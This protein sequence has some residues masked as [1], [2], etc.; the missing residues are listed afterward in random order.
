VVKTKTRAP[1][2]LESKESFSSR[3]RQGAWL[4]AFAAAFCALGDF[5]AM[6]L[7]LP[8]WRDRGLLLVK[9]L[10]TLVPLGFLAGP[11]VAGLL[12]ASTRLA[13]RRTGEV[14]AARFPWFL[15]ALGALPLHLLA[16][17]LC[18]G[19]MMSRLPQRGG[20]EVALT[21]LLPALL[22]G[23]L[24]AAFKG[25]RWAA[26]NQRRN[27]SLAA[28]LAA[29][30]F[31]LGKL[32]QTLYPNLY[33]YLHGGL[34]VVTWLC[35]GVVGALL[36]SDPRVGLVARRAAT[37]KHT[38]L[39][40]LVLTAVLAA[41]A[42]GLDDHLNVRVAM[43]DPRSPI[44]RSLLAAIDPV[45]S[46]MAKPPVRTHDR[47]LERAIVDTRGLPTR[48]G[49]HVVLVTIDAL[50]AD[51][52][53]LYG[54]A[55]PTSPALDALAKDSVVFA[56]AYAQAPHSS[57]SLT[58]LHT[59]EYMHE[60]VDLERPLP[61]ATLAQTFRDQGYH[62]AA[63]FTDG[64]FHTEGHRLQPYR[65][66]AFDFALF[67][68]T[69]REAEGQTDRVLAEADRVVQRG[70]TPS[71]FWV[72]YFD[73]HEPY[74]DTHFG[75][76]DVDR[77]DSEILH[78]DR[79]LARLLR[80]LDERFERDVVVAISADHG[81]EFR[82]HGGV[83][84]GSTLFDEQ[85]R[86][87]LIL[88]STGLPPSVVRAPVE[89]I[90]IAPTL[91][92]T[93]GIAPPASMRGKDL[94]AYDGETAAGSLAAFSAVISKRMAVR[95][96]YKLVADLRFGLYELYD[97][98]VD[99][100][101]RRNLAGS[102]PRVLE[103]MRGL[104]YAWLDSL[105]ADPGAQ[106]K[107]EPLYE[108]ALRWGRLG[109]R[110][111]V[112]PMVQLLRDTSA[113]TADRIE[114][115]Q[116]LA[117]LADE[118]SAEALFAALD[119]QP[120]EVAAEAAIALGRMYDERPREH[121][122]RLMD[123]EDPYVRARAAISLGRLRDA[124]AVDA[125]IDALW[126]A[127][128]QY[129]REEAVRWLGRLRDQRATEPLLSLV[130]EFG[131]R[132]L[133]AVALGQVA[134]PRSYDALSDMLTWETHTNVRD[135]VVRGLGLMGDKRALPALLTLLRSEPALQNT[136]EA[137]VR[138][139]ALDA[140]V[141]GGTDAAPGA[142]G[143]L[144]FGN[145]QAGP[146]WHDWDFVARTTCESGRARTELELPTGPARDRDAAVLLLR[147]GRSDAPGHAQ[148]TLHVGDDPNAPVLEF[149]ANASE[150]RVPLLGP[151][152]Q[153]PTLHVVL[154]SSPDDAR[155]VLDHALIVPSAAAEVGTT[156]ASE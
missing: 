156:T 62:T 129:E 142:T 78:T 4:G 139:G 95:L 42:R 98:S 105:E 132:Y 36:T 108:R 124:R 143:L 1:G 122:A 85:V 126:V 63:F 60:V 70:E 6:W 119:T 80:G 90:D 150:F 64:I 12:A 149:D 146:L 26:G 48:P 147:L 133:V 99:P 61:S 151:S 49:A 19:G 32:N 33:D 8:V 128:T 123:V 101:E 43:F 102:E 46:R 11:L 15:T 68:H 152:L 91:L 94:R 50:R 29:L 14:S 2:D 96:P 154:Q 120:P 25:F 121:L 10:A 138:L 110:R 111:A 103:E 18:S 34:A 74:Q 40:A 31:S 65:D 88:H 114:A 23:S 87:P 83:Y 77:Y 37:G 71:F 86:V 53:G 27:L 100:E 67:D 17:K 127:P 45:L 38:F 116:A 76:S 21:L 130:P 35:A 112:A 51:H 137:M 81:E 97:L 57:Y 55:R 75:T 52:L 134:D 155:F 107:D 115:G 136:A 24:F 44:S 28:A 58:S 131:L 69:N 13:T 84:H 72:H 3:L 141:I 22:Y 41:D 106:A 73:V 93:V 118:S 109:D 5:G 79:E 59:S 153:K 30:A 104:V 140:R 125:L 20:I 144:G 56:R 117:K 113:P 16:R 135:E 9:L 145:C 7:W 66:S 47:T 89:V 39:T 54:Y 82:D 148:L 92:G